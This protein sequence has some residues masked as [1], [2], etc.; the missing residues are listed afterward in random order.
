M[1][2]SNVLS[3]LVALGIIAAIGYLFMNWNSGATSDDD[4]S[5]Y[6]ERSCIDEMR[7]RYDSTRVRVNSV[8]PNSNGFV[9][10]GNM[11][12]ARGGTAKLT[13]LTNHHGRVTEVIIEER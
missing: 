13:C 2:A 3:N 8:E 9:V 1:R 11:T 7:S 10:K 6:A 5:T 4:N 12:L